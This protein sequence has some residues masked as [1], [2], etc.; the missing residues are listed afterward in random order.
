MGTRRIARPAEPAA[1]APARR[2]A[3][4]LL[5][6]GRWFEALLGL[7]SEGI[8]VV[9]AGRIREGNDFLSRHGGYS[10]A[11]VQGTLLAS[12][13]ESRSAAVVEALCRRRR[14]RPGGDAPQDLY[15]VGKN[16]RRKK[17]RLTAR[18]CRL[19]GRPALLVVLASPSPSAP[20]SRWSGLPEAAWF[21][22][23]A[24]VETA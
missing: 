4:R 20:A 6:R 13:F 18:S 11:E 10:R 9:Q 16:G 22:E 14:L 8:F 17:V 19:D 23:E 3:R 7:A 5:E 24:A 12:F 1:A 15:L 21:P 2:R